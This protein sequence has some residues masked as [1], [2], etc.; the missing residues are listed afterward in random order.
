MLRSFLRIA[1]F[2][3][4]WG[5]VLGVG[6]LCVREWEEHPDRFVARG[7]LSAWLL[8]GAFAI[9]NWRRGSRKSSLGIRIFRNVVLPILLSG[10]TLKNGLKLYDRSFPVPQV[11]DTGAL[12]CKS[13]TQQLESELRVDLSS[14]FK[15]VPSD[16]LPPD[17]VTLEESDS[18]EVRKQ[19]VEKAFQQGGHLAFSAEMTGRYHTERQ[20]EARQ[21]IRGILRYGRRDPVLCALLAKLAR[22]ENLPEE[23]LHVLQLLHSTH[24]PAPQ[25][26]RERKLRALLGRETQDNT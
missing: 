3:G 21:R 20:L 11:P 13:M 24:P 6:L 2:F 1:G 18:P 15:E 14:L 17:T 12:L 4:A 10:I 22:K 19:K 8:F 23:E 9:W 26:E 7:L 5:V 25:P 16:Q